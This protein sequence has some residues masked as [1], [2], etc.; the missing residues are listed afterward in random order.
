V[1]ATT[2]NRPRGERMR[3]GGVHAVIYSGNWSG[4]GGT[5]T[6]IL[7]A[8]GNWVVPAV[9]SSTS[10]LYSASWIGVDGLN[11]SNL[12]QTGTEQDTAY[13]YYAWYEILPAS[14][15]MIVDST[16]RPAPVV[17]GDQMAAG[18]ART[19]AGVWTIDLQD[20]TRGWYFQQDFSYGGPG[21][22]AEWIEEAPTVNGAQT[23]PANFGTAHFSGTAEY[24]NFGSGLG[25]Y[26]T[27]MNANNEIAME[28]QAGT[29]ILAMPSAPS[30]PSTTGQSFTDT[31]VVAPSA[32]TN[33]TARPGVA[34]V[35]L[36]WNPPISNGGTPITSYYVRVFK[37]GVLQRTMTVTGT[38]TT[39]GQ[40]TSGAP[41]TFAVAAHS[42]GN[43]TSVY[44]PRTPTVWP[45]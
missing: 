9:K 29:R 35:G 22:S 4:L 16:G 38:S 7:G 18:V 41:Y 24:A 28:N 13:G 39:V 8:A 25:W 26:G 19:A 20:N 21:Q 42:F 45:A 27:T 44:S 17:P 37:A 31:Y 23:T 33:L 12:I 32:P 5:G 30:A 14:E 3:A 43:Y 1:A 40:L 15:T 36:S 11:N 6:G 34:A 2:F 10:P